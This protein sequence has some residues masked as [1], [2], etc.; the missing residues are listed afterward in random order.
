MVLQ[1][2]GVEMRR[3]GQKNRG[4]VRASIFGGGRRVCLLLGEESGLDVVFDE[5]GVEMEAFFQLVDFGVDEETVA[6]ALEDVPNEA[7]F[8]VEETELE[9]VAVGEVDEGTEK[10]WKFY[11]FD[12]QPSL[13]LLLRAE[14]LGYDLGG[15]GVEVEFHEE[16]VYHLAGCVFVVLVHPPR[17][18]VEIGVD[19]V[20]VVDGD[21]VAVEEADMLVHPTVFALTMASSPDFEVVAWVPA[22]VHEWSAEEVDASADV[23]A[24]DVVGAILNGFQDVLSE[25]LIEVLVGID[26]P[27]PVGRE[28]AVLETPVE[29]CGVVGPG[30]LEDLCAEAFGDF[31]G[32]VLAE[33]VDDEDLLTDALEGV[34]ASGDMFFLVE[35]ED[36]GSDGRHGGG[37]G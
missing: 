8:A 6:E 28:W 7:F 35:G 10:E 12:F 21:G 31:L 3:L 36:D 37:G 32:A 9:E 22:T 16:R 17:E 11:V 23:D 29:L 18:V 27:D 26:A 24:C 30:V 20:A 14:E 19:L 13:A 34:D 33:A 2:G 5:L 4:S 1:S 25:V 15:G